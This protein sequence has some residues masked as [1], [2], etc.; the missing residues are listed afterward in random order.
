MQEKRDHSFGRLYACKAILQSDVCLQKEG[1]LEAWSDNIELVAILAKS[2]PWIRE[3]TGIVFCDAIKKLPQV[4]FAPSYVKSCFNILQQYQL[5]DSPEGVAIWLTVQLQIPSFKDYPKGIWAHHDPL[6]KENMSKLNQT[7][8][9]QYREQD[10]A[11]ADSLKAGFWQQSVSFSWSV[12]LEAAIAADA[13]LK[14]FD[15]TWRNIVDGS[16]PQVIHSYR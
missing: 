12:V 16:T 11:K 1:D 4:S 14:T 5:I 7:M 13:G 3:E 9:E 8:R 10:I 6:H 2:T 15:L